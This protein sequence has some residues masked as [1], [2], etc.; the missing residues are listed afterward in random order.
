MTLVHQAI[1]PGLRAASIKRLLATLD[2]GAKIDGRQFTIS[3]ARSVATSAAV[4]IFTPTIINY[5]HMLVRY[6]FATAAVISNVLHTDLLTSN[7]ISTDA[8]ASLRDEH[9]SGQTDTSLMFWPSTNPQTLIINKRI[10][11]WRTVYKFLYFNSGA[12]AQM[13]Q[14]VTLIPLGVR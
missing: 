12:A 4:Q 11:R 5:P 14:S 1:D 8:A 9:L 7:D 6:L 10:L 3:D 2:D 13:A